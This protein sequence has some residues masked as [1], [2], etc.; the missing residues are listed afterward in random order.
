MPKAR[1]KK[2]AGCQLRMALESLLQ[3]CRDAVDS[4]DSD[5]DGSAHFIRTRAKRLQSLCRLLP[6]GKRWRRSFLPTCRE[7]KDMFAEM[8][9]A[10]IVRHLAEH[11][12]P[13]EA[14]HL[15]VVTPPDLAGAAAL[16]RVADDALAGYP[17]W[18]GVTWC[19]V[20]DRAVG[21]YRA[22][23]QAWKKAACKGAPDEAFHQWRRR[24]KRLLYQSEFLGRRASLARFTKRVDRLGEVLGNLQ[25]ATVAADWLRDHAKTEVPV[26]LEKA[27]AAARGGALEMGAILFDPKPRCFRERLG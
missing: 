18:D 13:G 8:R 1:G 16:S 2:S 11:Y 5:P 6:R 20:S 25:D 17:L 7:L 21:T 24:V 19:D 26:E 4:F 12:T 22:A 23:R 15:R 9:D 10:T 27:A 14:H 3:Q